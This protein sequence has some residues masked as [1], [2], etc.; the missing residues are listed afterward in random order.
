MNI[1]VLMSKLFVFMIVLISVGCGTS[2]SSVE[3]TSTALPIEPT[4]EIAP[5]EESL[6]PTSTLTPTRAILAT[7]VPSQ[8]PS[9]TS[10][11]STVVL[12]PTAEP[13]LS[14]TE[15]T[16]FVL[17]LLQVNDDCLFPCWWGA[18]PAETTW[19]EFEP[20]LAR[21]ATEIINLE[22][23]RPNNPLETYEVHINVPME[24][25]PTDQLILFYTT[26][27]GVIEN[28]EIE[29]GNSPTYSLPELLT[30]YG[31]PSDV[32][33]SSYSHSRDNNLPFRTILFYLDQGFMVTYFDNAEE[34]SDNIVGCPQQSDNQFIRAWLW[35]PESEIVIEDVFN[36]SSLI[37]QTQA[38]LPLEAATN[39][40]LE[41]FYEIFKEAN[42]TSCIETPADLWPSP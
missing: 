39:I 41:D 28:I 25:S 31:P 9:Q 13:T 19:Q 26:R 7:P 38:Y 14:S 22:S 36:K 33:L 20:F 34:K 27:N 30:Q 6:P 15:A 3:P 24:I 40:D 8:T 29:L 16:A 35:Y 32:W 18:T 21:F 12:T 10:S 4:G 1:Q 11:S 17:N 37:D 42:N 5:F 2:A 23:I